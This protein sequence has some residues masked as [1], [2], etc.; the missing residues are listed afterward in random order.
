METLSVL[1]AVLFS[2][3]IAVVVTL[4]WERRKDR[5]ALKH[6][7]FVTLMGGRHTPLSD[8][9]IRALNLI[10]VAFHDDPGVRRLWREYF[11]ML[12]NEGLSNPA[13]VQTRQ[14][15]NLELITAMGGTLGYGADISHLDVDRVYYPV[16]LADQVRR[17]Q[18]IADQVPRLLRAITEGLAARS[19]TQGGARPVTGDG[20]PPAG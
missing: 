20:P 2:P 11:D 4:W 8:Q 6:W 5:R 14:R 16:A 3:V 7:I 13:G 10:D 18:E 1:V 9:T 12:N 17:G 15:K 19:G